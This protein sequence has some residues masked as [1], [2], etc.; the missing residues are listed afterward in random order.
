MV[1]GDSAIGFSRRSDGSSVSVVVA[2]SKRDAR[3]NLS[4]AYI[5]ACTVTTLVS[6]ATV[7]Y[8]SQ[9]VRP[10]FSYW[11]CLDTTAMVTQTDCNPR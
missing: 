11:Q 6:L 4:A 8:P 10:P 5:S 7:Q 9:A 1:G 2:I 3:T